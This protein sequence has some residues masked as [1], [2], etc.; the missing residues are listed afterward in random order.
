[1]EFE[2]FIISSALSK[3]DQ[4]ISIATSIVVSRA[5]NRLVLGLHTAKSYFVIP[6]D[7]GN[8]FLWKLKLWKNTIMY[9]IYGYILWVMESAF[10]GNWLLQNLQFMEIALM[11]KYSYI[12]KFTIMKISSLFTTFIIK[13]S[14][15]QIN[16]SQHKVQTPKAFYGNCIYEKISLG[17][18]TIMK[19]YNY[20]KIPLWT[21]I[22]MKISNSFTTTEKWNRQ[23]LPNLAQI[24][25]K[26]KTIRNDDK[27]G[28]VGIIIWHNFD[29]YC[30]EGALC[31]TSFC[32]TNPPCD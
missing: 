3:N 15:R 16:R 22:I 12:W 8:R 21:N 28:N 14:R 30:K 23:I 4:L 7:Y 17:T 5:D 9:I 1:M 10:Y 25:T 19:I 13:Y 29:S 20:E 11:K 26:S 24:N 31:E 32:A 18:F 2:I 6:N 27:I